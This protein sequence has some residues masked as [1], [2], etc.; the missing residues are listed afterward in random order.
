MAMDHDVQQK[1]QGDQQHEIDH[2]DVEVRAAS[3]KKADLVPLIASVRSP[4]TSP[5][6]LPTSPAVATASTSSASLQRPTPFFRTI[7]LSSSHSTVS[8][9]SHSTVSSSSSTSL[10]SLSTTSSTAS[11]P[12]KHTISHAANSNHTVMTVAKLE[13]SAGGIGSTSPLASFSPPASPFSSKETVQSSITTTTTTTTTTSSNVSSKKSTGKTP[14]NKHDDP[15]AEEDSVKKPIRKLGP[16]MNPVYKG[17]RALVWALYFDLGASLISMTQVL[18]LPLA[19]IAPG[20]YHRH[21]KRTEGHFGAFLLKMNQLFAPSDI[22]LTGD[23]SIKGIVKA[24]RGDAS[25]HSTNDILLDMPDRCIFISNHQIYSDWMYLWC[26]SYFAE[27][28]SA[29]KIILRGDLTW[30]PVFGWGMRFFDFILLKRNDWVHD[31]H[32]IEENLDRASKKE[33]L[34]LVVFPEGTVVSKGTRKR[35]AAF[36]EKEGLTDHRHVLLPRT[37]GLFVC[38]NKLRGS[39]EYLYDATVGYSGIHIGEIP[40]ELYPLPG[41]Y[42]NKAQ[43]KEVNMHLRRFAIKDIPETEPEFIEWVRVRWQ[44]KDDLMDEFYTTGKFPSKLTTEDIDGTVEEPIDGKKKEG[45]SIRI[46]L[47]SRKMLD[48]LSPSAINVIALPILAFAIRYAL[49]RSE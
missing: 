3:A 15:D 10:S 38:I 2:V 4:D 32:A 21:I 30:I 33:P 42:I 40:Q 48:Y 6:S 14:K 5:V 35:S 49:L 13:P 11:Q 27:K 45:K 43:P 8:S 26:F 39:V 31:K 18:S 47:K 34:W 41:L 36:A 16:K 29:L 23:E 7:S 9:S 19:L 44:E 22:I 17:L 24:H 1:Q 12:N 37:S 25:N 20:V 46:P 28:H